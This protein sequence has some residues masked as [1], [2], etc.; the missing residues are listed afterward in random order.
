MKKFLLPFF[1]MLPF[2]LP[3]QEADSLRIVAQLESEG[4]YIAHTVD[5][6]GR[7]L[8][9]RAKRDPG[10]TVN[11]CYYDGCLTELLRFTA[12]DKKPETVALFRWPVQAHDL[13]VDSSGNILVAAGETIRDTVVRRLRYKGQVLKYDASLNLL[14]KKEITGGM[15]VKMYITRSNYY[16]LFRQQDTLKFGTLVCPQEKTFYYYDNA[17]VLKTDMNFTVS[18][19]ATRPVEGMFQDGEG[20]TVSPGGAVAVYTNTC[21]LRRADHH[22]AHIFYFNPAGEMNWHKQFTCSPYGGCLGS[23]MCRAIV[24]EKNNELIASVSSATAMLSWAANDTLSHDA[25]IRNRHLDKNWKPGGQ[26]KS[27]YSAATEQQLVFFRPSGQ[28]ESVPVPGSLCHAQFF[29]DGETLCMLQTSTTYRHPDY[30]YSTKL[31]K[32]NKDTHALKNAGVAKGN[33]LLVSN[34]GKYCTADNR[35][36][37]PYHDKFVLYEMLLRGK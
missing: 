24:F 4:R 25:E 20:I 14:S 32:L 13:A 8:V 11:N 31:V 29:R 10:S 33:L 1:V 30:S 36:Y 12:L 37:N 9:L 2:V 7:V 35:S 21:I 17:A 3:A 15:P 6:T 19:F 22:D 34:G 28:F 18:W 16:F 27:G 5:K 26:E 23:N